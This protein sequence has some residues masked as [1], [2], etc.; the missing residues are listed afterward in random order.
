M[1]DSHSIP[2]IGKKWIQ[3]CIVPLLIFVFT[4]CLVCPWFDSGFPSTVDHTTH[5][6]RCYLTEQALW[7]HGSL[8]PWTS[9]I[10][11]GVPLNDLYPPGGAMLFCAI[12]ALSLFLVNLFTA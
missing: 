5:L 4:L 12:R 9:A 10:G 3:E 6:L 2:T 11:S 1:Y 8:L 7:N